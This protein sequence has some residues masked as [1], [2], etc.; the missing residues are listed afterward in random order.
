MVDAKDDKE[1]GDRGAPV[2]V[3]SLVAL[4]GGARHPLE[5]VEVVAIEELGPVQSA[6]AISLTRSRNQT[7][8]ELL[9]NPAGVLRV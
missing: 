1:D 4:D 5:A 8:A 6:A 3:A 7:T 2:V 9:L